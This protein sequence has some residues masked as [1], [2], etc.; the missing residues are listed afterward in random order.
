MATGAS[1]GPIEL[2]MT[3]AAVRAALGAP[4]VESNGFLQYYRDGISVALTDDGTVDALH[5]FRGVPGGYENEPWSLFELRLPSGL[6]WDST[7][8]QVRATM[9]A[10]AGE[11]ALSEAPIPSKWIDYGGVMFDFRID[12]GRMFHV[13]IAAD[14]SPPPAK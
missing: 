7:E 13:V 14:G 10:P 1:A 5:V 2:G 9:G 4:S 6:G 12:D 8:A 3:A 11:G